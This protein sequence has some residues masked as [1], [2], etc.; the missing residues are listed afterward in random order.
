MTAM[1]EKFENEIFLEF[2]KKYSNN[3]TKF[4]LLGVSD[5]T[6]SDILVIKKD[7]PEFYMEIKSSI[8]QAAQFALNQNSE[9]KWYFSDLNK[10]TSTNNSE[11]IIGFINKSDFGAITTSGISIGIDQKTQFDWIKDF[12]EERCVEFVVTSYNNEL[13]IMPLENIHIYFNVSVIVRKKGSGSAELSNPV[14]RKIKNHPVFNG[15]R[16]N[17]VINGKRYLTFDSLP[18]SLNNNKTIF[19]DMFDDEIIRFQLEIISDRKVYIRKLSNTS[20]PTVI[21]TLTSKRSQISEDMA[22]FIER[23]T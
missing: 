11:E 4:E 20:N 13:V 7:E 5:S 18:E 9:K 16:E 15:V 8:A 21:F 23:I 19:A 2:K 10:T 22:Y 12:Y 1:W 14:W 3:N 17:N 6:Q